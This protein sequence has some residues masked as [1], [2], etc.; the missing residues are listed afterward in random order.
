MQTNW[1]DFRKYFGI[2]SIIKATLILVAQNLL[3]L[4]VVPM[5]HASDIVIQQ[6][7]KIRDDRHKKKQTG[8]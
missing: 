2:L 4:C 6:L 7:Q 5:L 1:I 8:E 3:H